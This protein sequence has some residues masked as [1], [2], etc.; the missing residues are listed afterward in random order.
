MKTPTLDASGDYVCEHGT[1]MDV[2]CCNCH[3]GFLF[4]PDSCVCDFDEEGHV[5]NDID[6]DCGM[7]RHGN[8]GQA[9]SEECDFECPFRNVK[10]N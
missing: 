6:F 5:F 1:A 4:D 7:D 8:C 2:H 10:R 3:S 9:G